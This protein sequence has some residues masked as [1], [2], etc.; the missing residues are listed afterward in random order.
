VP[1]LRNAAAATPHPAAAAAARTVFAAGGNA[2]DAAVAAMLTCC[3][4][5]PAMVGL[6][7]Y[8][9][10]LVAYLTDARQTVAI[11]FDSCAPLAYQPEAF[12]R[13]RADYDS[14]YLSI[15]VPAVVAGLELARS[16]FGTMPWEALSAPAVGL[17][18]SGVPV[19]AGLR[20]RLEG[21]VTRADPV[22]R[23]TLLADKAVS[24]IGDVWVQHDLERLLLRLA[25]EGPA[26]FYEGDIPQKIVRQIR[27]NGGILGESDFRTY[28]AR[29]VDPIS[30]DYRSFRVFT[31]PPPSGGITALE[32]LDALSSHEIAG[33]TRSGSRYYHLIAE[34]ARRA[35]ANRG[36]L[37][38]PD[39]PHTV[40]VVTGD[41]AGNI[42]SMTA[43]LGY[44]FGSAVVIDGFGLVMNHGMS[45]FDLTPGSAN[46]PAPGKR[47]MHN[48][49]PTIILNADGEPFAAVGLPGG[50]KIVTVTAQLVSSLVDFGMPPAEAVQA[51]RIHAETDGPLAVSAAVP[52]EVI[53]ELKSLGH[54]VRRGQ[55]V[56]GPPTEIGGVANAL[57]IDPKTGV[58]SAASQ[59]GSDAAVN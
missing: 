46:A 16:Q 10:S 25:T 7:G 21:W 35:W 12:A 26:A 23:Q 22:S 48:M 37:S 28:R 52:D 42:V 9:G 38:D 58:V 6:G 54:S 4:A 34:G 43:T 20:R 50:P 3:V 57:L 41:T 39:F 47:M 56:G 32:M 8:G 27:E 15:T 44:L 11:D 51:G 33:L 55:D 36:K 14:G 53:D 19:T 13:G 49:A 1:R 2:V 31:P 17:A 30:T 59:A 18:R 45:R 5:E 24:Q 29:I 40:N